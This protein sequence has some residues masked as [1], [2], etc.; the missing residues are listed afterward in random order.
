MTTYPTELVPTANG[1]Q[2]YMTPPAEAAD[3]LA[4][5]QSQ[6]SPVMQIVLAFGALREHVAALDPDGLVVLASCAEVLVLKNFSN[7]AAE[8]LPVR[9]AAIAQ[10]TS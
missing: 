7:L 3:A 10:M 9:D 8:A 5:A 1:I 6:P 2:A 4:Y